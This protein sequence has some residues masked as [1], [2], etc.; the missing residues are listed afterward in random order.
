MGPKYVATWIRI[1]FGNE[2]IAIVQETWE[3]VLETLI[4][5]ANYWKSGHNDLDRS[6]GADAHAQ[7]HLHA[8]EKSHKLNTM[9]RYWL[10]FFALLFGFIFIVRLHP[11]FLI[12]H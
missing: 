12:P 1:K 2:T 4:H 11:L 8:D 7:A 6:Q 10:G 5:Y 3:D 9:D